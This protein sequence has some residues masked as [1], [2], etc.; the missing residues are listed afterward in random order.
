MSLGEKDLKPIV[1]ILELHCYIVYQTRRSLCLCHE[2]LSKMVSYSESAPTKR[3]QV[4]SLEEHSLTGCENPT[5]MRECTG[6]IP[7]RC[8]PFYDQSQDGK[9]DV[10]SR[11][12]QNRRRC[13]ANMRLMQ[14]MERVKYLFISI[15][16][17][18]FI[19]SLRVSPNRS[20]PN[21]TVPPHLP[22][23]SETSIREFLRGKSK[24]FRLDNHRSYLL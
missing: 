4:V 18:F 20:A 19:G 2:R 8:E 23:L 7:A 22:V 5:E 13:A 3:I 12:G 16:R 21:P 10:Q 17:L 11:L 15:I 6:G 24:V 9:A 14:A 1:E